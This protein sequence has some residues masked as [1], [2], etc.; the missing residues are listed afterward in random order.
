MRK[1]KPLNESRKTGKPSGT[2]TAF[3]SLIFHPLN[4]L[5]INCAKTG[6]IMNFRNNYLNLKTT[7]HLM[8]YSVWQPQEVYQN[9][10]LHQYPDKKT[11]VIQ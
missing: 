9:L 8:A 11:I 5:S 7:T 4:L 6:L 2:K 10:F 3:Y 1:N